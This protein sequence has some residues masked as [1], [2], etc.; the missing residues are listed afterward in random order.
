MDDYQEMER[1]GMEND[2]D[3]GQWIGGEFYYRK[4]KE[5][6][7]QTKDDVLYGVFATGS[8]SDSDGFSSRKRRKDR[9]L[10]RKPDLTKPVNFVSTGT[11]MPDQEIDKISKDGDT[12]NADDD[13]PGLGLGSSTSGS[14]LGFTS[15]SSDRNR[16]GVKE[17]GS[18]GDGDEDGDDLFLLTAFGRRIKEGAERRERERVKSQVEKKSRAVAGT[19]KDSNL[20]NVGVFEKHTK[21]IGLKLLEKMGYKGGGLGRNEQ[22]IV[23]PIEAKM[24][25][26]NMGMGFNDFQEAPKIPVLQE[27]E[28]KILPQPTTKAKERLWSKQVR[29]KKKKKEAYLTAEELLASKQDQALE[30]VQKVFDMRGPQ[31]RVLTKFRKLEC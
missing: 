8:D 28:E 27:I 4:R 13:R 19:R 14:G 5:K 16:N 26:K 3:D 11:V 7:S 25:P 1:F 24:R 12:D 30:V 20:G 2:Y 18:T 21:G 31:V 9:D 17:N 10:S 23:A 29:S 15:S 22:G 6:R